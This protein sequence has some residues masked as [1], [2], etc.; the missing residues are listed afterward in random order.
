MGVAKSVSFRASAAPARACAA[1]HIICRARVALS[2]A[3]APPATPPSH[4]GTYLDSPGGRARACCGGTSTLRSVHGGYPAPHNSRVSP[5]RERRRRCKRSQ[6]ARE[7]AR[8]W[9]VH[10]AAQHVW[11]LQSAE[12]GAHFPVKNVNPYPKRASHPWKAGSGRVSRSH[13]PGQ[14]VLEAIEALPGAR[15][16]GKQ[17]ASVNVLYISSAG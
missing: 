4:C 14:G 5:A 11:T 16:G 6:L 15:H 2:S 10:R 12:I 9:V 3:P 8:V 17:L 13:C 7:L 1:L